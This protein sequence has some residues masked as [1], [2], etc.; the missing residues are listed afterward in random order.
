MTTRTAADTAASTETD[1]DLLTPQEVATMLRIA[2]STL[3]QWRGQ[4]KGPK[5]RK[6]GDGI[7]SPVRY[8]RG[9]VREFLED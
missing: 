2:V 8:R 6:L 9:D 7:R 1:D 5:Y 3:E 4:R